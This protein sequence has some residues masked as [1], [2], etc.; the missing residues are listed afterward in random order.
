MQAMETSTDMHRVFAFILCLALLLGCALPGQAQTVTVD[1][2][3]P[4]QSKMFIALA[5]PLS[6]GGGA[7]ASGNALN[8]L[9]S[10]NLSFL[11]FLEQLSPSSILGGVK[12]DGYDRDA[13]DFKRF[14]LAGAD[15][16]LT[17]GWTSPTSVEL[18][19]FEA[20]TKQLV[21]GKAYSI[22]SEKQLAEVADKFCSA[23]MEKLTGHGEF[24]LSSLAFVRSTGDSKNIF[25]SHA[26]GRDVRQ[27]TSLEGYN[28]SPDWSP[29]GAVVFTHIGVTREDRYHSLC[30]LSGGGVSKKRY[31]NSA[32]ISPAYIGGSGIAVGMSGN[33]NVDIYRVNQDLTDRSV[34]VSSN[35]IDVSPSFDASGSRM[36][37]VSDRQGGPQVYV[38]GTGG[39]ASR[40]TYQGSYNTDPSLSPDGKLVAF[41]KQTGA[42][43]RIFVLDLE[44]GQETQISFGPGSDEQPAFA[45]DGYFIAYTSGGRIFLTTR[46]GDPRKEI[47]CGGGTLPAWKG[48]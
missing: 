27:L 16:L 35:A 36:A 15:L 34:L 25:A 41:T 2:Y 31:G 24:F 20:F 19:V 21:V 32:V 10:S 18:R 29:G 17:A 46:H 42:G 1:I 6:S 26:T 44:S 22:T 11:P 13:I 23:L 9:L 4:G 43:Y 5:D 33:G 8:S 30:V 48:P 14:Q 39:S 28:L 45:P 3:G 7:P 40:V 38:G 12:L 47:P 37:F